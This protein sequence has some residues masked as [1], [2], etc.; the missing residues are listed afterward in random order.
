MTAHDTKTTPPELLEWIDEQLDRTGLSDSEASRR[1]G[2]S[3][4][5]IYEIRSG[6]RPGLK[7]CVALAE[8]FGVPTDYVLRLAGHLPPRPSTAISDVPRLQH[9]AE[10]VAALPEGRQRVVIDAFLSLLDAQEMASET[11]QRMEKTT[12]GSAGEGGG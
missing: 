12:N 3:H 6:L 5:A 1:A 7:K 9:L 8:F 4:V 10:R 11:L 2:L